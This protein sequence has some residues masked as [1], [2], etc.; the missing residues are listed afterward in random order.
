[1][2]GDHLSRISRTVLGLDEEQLVIWGIRCSSNGLLHVVIGDSEIL[3]EQN[4]IHSLH[5]YRVGELDVWCPHS[6][7]VITL[8]VN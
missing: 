7:S 8:T 6:C 2:Q 5:T 4:I 3:G 1:M